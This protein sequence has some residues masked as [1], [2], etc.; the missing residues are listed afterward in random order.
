MTGQEASFAV[1]ASALDGQ[2]LPSHRLDSHALNI[3]DGATNEI[4]SSMFHVQE[5]VVDARRRLF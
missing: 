2:W 4:F 1:L 5:A 3:A